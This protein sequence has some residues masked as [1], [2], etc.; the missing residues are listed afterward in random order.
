MARATLSRKG[1]RAL[2][3]YN[4]ADRSVT[5]GSCIN[6]PCTNPFK[7]GFAASK[8]RLDTSIR[9]K[10]IGNIVKVPGIYG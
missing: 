6:P 8:P 7:T 9:V 4:G 1:E 2:Q 5:V 10:S 3:K